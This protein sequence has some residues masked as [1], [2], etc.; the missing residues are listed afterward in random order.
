M[1]D[2]PPTVPRLVSEV[3]G[4]LPSVLEEV[5]GQLAT[6]HPGYAGFVDAEFR[7]VLA[8]AEAFT[9]RVFRVAAEGH[10][11]RSGFVTDGERALFM[12]IGREHYHQHRDIDALLA[13][14]RIGAAVAWRHIADVALRHRLPS[15]RFAGLAAAVFAAVEELSAASRQGYVA[16][17][18][19]RRQSVRRHRQEL[20]ELLLSE[21]PSRAAIDAVAARAD[22]PVPERAAV[23]L[24]HD[25]DAGV[26][27]RLDALDGHGVLGDGPVVVV[28]EP[29]RPGRS[30]HL[31]AL[32]HGRGA[33]LGSTVPVDRLRTGLELARL[34]ARL[35]DRGLLT[36]DPL[37]VDDHLDA[38]IVHRD[39]QLLEALR[40]RLLAPV[41]ELPGSS[42]ERLVE[43][44]GSWLLHLG[45]GRAVAEEL[46]VHPQTVR[47]RLGRLRELLDLD[48][49]RHR[50]ALLLAVGWPGV[51]P[52]GGGGTDAGRS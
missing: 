36:G 25:A 17:E 40:T 27:E 2:E 48:T 33:V 47:Y 43:T 50:A 6:Q 10:H 18:D 5:A 46:H 11:S 16:A 31:R 30:E 23:V 37:V 21:G 51:D 12:T 42:A 38:L 44:L 3:V 49:P 52:T 35:R 9:E 14:Y 32:L 15:T 26:L 19:E 7:N 8:G 22:W 29:D 28:P 20:L 13:A 39:E 1:A 41:L 34:A 24:A 4:R 45:N